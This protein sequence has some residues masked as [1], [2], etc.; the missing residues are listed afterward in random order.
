V[1]RVRLPTG[2]AVDVHEANGQV[3]FLGTDATVDVVDLIALAAMF[4]AC[5][6]PVRRESGDSIPAAQTPAEMFSAVGEGAGRPDPPVLNKSGG[7]HVH[8]KMR[9]YHRSGYYSDAPCAE[10]GAAA[11]EPCK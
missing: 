5:A 8:A 9:T 7:S 2:R 6:Y 3:D 11:G 10:C 1:S 4:Q